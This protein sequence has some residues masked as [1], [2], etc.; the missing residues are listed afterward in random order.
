MKLIQLSDPHLASPGQ[1][2][3]GIDPYRR[4]EEAIADINTHHADADLVVF[5][6]DLADD[7]ADQAYAALAQ[8]LSALAAPWR[9]TLGNHDRRAAFLARFP[10]LADENGFVQS[11][12]DMGG[13]RV[14]VLDSLA[15]GEV[16]GTLCRARLAWLE[17]QLREAAG[18][19]ALLFLHHPPMPIGLPAQDAVRL[20]TTATEALYALCQR[21]GRV[22]HIAAGHVH[23]SA[24]GVWRGIGFSTVRGTCHQSAFAPRFEIGFEPPQYAI[25]LTGD[26]GY[27]V[28][29]HDFQVAA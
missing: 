8:R 17:R 11:A 10:A 26:D 18:Q 13:E 21:H 29:F 15:E 25:F 24:A 28:H 4:L 2:L 5:S 6:G 27:T 23:R 16:G 7:G 14:L 20:D 3:S 22:R 19:P 1:L 12:T 9:L